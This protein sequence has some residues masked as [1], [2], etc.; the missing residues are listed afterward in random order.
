MLLRSFNNLLFVLWIKVVH[1]LGLCIWHECTRLS[2]LDSYEWFEWIEIFFWT[3]VF[4]ECTLASFIDKCTAAGHT[5]LLAFLCFKYTCDTVYVPYCNQLYN[6]DPA[7]R[8]KTLY[9]RFLVFLFLNDERFSV[10]IYY[11]HLI[12]NWVSPNWNTGHFSILCDRMVS[13]SLAMMNVFQDLV[14]LKLVF[15]LLGQWT[16]LA[17]LVWNFFAP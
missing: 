3:S 15:H 8:Y 17:D 2:A 10:P 9:F 11:T 13:D 16:S 6:V 1:L 14:F 7:E 12:Y 5:P 4:L